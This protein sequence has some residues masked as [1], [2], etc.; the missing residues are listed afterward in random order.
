MEPQEWS[1]LLGLPLAP[2]SAALG[3]LDEGDNEF[4]QQIKLKLSQSDNEDEQRTAQL[5]YDNTRLGKVHQKCKI[6]VLK[7]P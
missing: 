3:K 2:V 5:Q 4:L 6:I 1:Q 7:F